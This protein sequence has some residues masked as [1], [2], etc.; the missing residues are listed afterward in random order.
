M[1]TARQLPYV[2]A[3]TI[4]M[5]VQPL[6]VKLSQHDG[7]IEYNSSSAVLLM[8]LAKIIISAGM[9]YTSGNGDPIRFET[10]DLLKYAT[11]AFIYFINNNV[12]FSIL[13]RVDATTYQLVGQ[14]KT[15]FTAI[16]F[17]L[18]LARTL[19]FYQ[20]LA[21]WQLAAG[22][23]VSQIPKGCEAHTQSSSF[24][25][26]VLLIGSCVLSAMGGIYNE[27]LLKEDNKLSIHMQNILLYTWGIAFNTAGVLL[28]GPEMITPSRFFNGY[29]FWTVI[30]VLNNALN[31]LAISAIL[32]YADN[33]AR[34]YA[35]AAAMLTTMLA[36]VLIFGDAFT[37]QLCLAMAVVFASAIQYNVK[38]EQLGWE[39]DKPQ[40]ASPAKPTVIGRSPDVELTKRPT[41]D[42]LEG[43][44]DEE[45]ALLKTKG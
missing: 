33:I 22:V 8:E 35:S 43:G 16:L 19:S 28:H 31:G 2:L 12:T 27:K 23:A 32:K 25:G 15:V 42:D 21:V 6:F 10:K 44:S 45:D 39:S 1:I 41:K 30:V 11:P 24:F 40:G 3:G 13:A 7:K 14:L 5:T 38:P 4:L 34:V 9:L 36:S 18:V 17:R 20:Y 29:N 37:P 26:V